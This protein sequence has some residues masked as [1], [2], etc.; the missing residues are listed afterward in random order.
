MMLFFLKSS[1]CLLVFYGFYTF[2]LSKE[3]FY[4]R[5]R[6][7]LL[8]CPAFAMIIPQLD[9]SFFQSSSEWAGALSLENIEVSLQS[10]PETQNTSGLWFSQGLLW[11]IYG[12][13]VLLF[14]GRLLFRLVNLIFT[15][16]K[17]DIKYCRGYKL[18]YTKGKFPTFS[19]FGYLF[20]DE[21][22]LLDEEKADKIL[23]HEQKHIWDGHSY[24]I[25][26]M[27]VMK[28]IFWFN[29]LIYLYH[30][31]L[32]LQHEYIADAYVLH[33]SDP[34]SYSR[35]IVEACFQK[36]NLS[37]AHSFFKKSEIKQR[38]QAIH[39]MRTPAIHG[40]KLLLLIPLL[41]L[42]FFSFAQRDVSLSTKNASPDTEMN[43]FAT[44]EGGLDKFYED[45]SQYLVYPQSSAKAGITGKVFVQFTVMKDGSVADLEVVKGLDKACNKAALSAFRKTKTRWLPAK[46]DG[47]V[48]KQQLSIPINFSLKK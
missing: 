15:I 47:K 41:A 18:I 35:I 9:L 32:K 20:W 8:L 34:K 5:N 33:E 38:V 2:F 46:V 13:M 31:S 37:L 22:L 48:V 29:P 21:T 6:Y 24:D 44:A 11:K 43:R 12:L 26:Y 40:L 23:M 19:F 28:I 42:L 10:N 36:L 25:L 1:L 45:L 30:R 4:Q 14:T 3:T 39:Q 16:Q 27:E 17:S 7:F